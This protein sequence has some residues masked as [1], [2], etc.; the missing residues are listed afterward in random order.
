MIKRI[1]LVNLGLN[2]SID[3]N[4][5]SK[6]SQKEFI[7][8]NKK[9]EV[10]RSLYEFYVR[11]SA[12]VD[13]NDGYLM[14]YKDILDASGDPTGE[15]TTTK[16]YSDA[17]R[18]YVGAS[19]LPDIIGGFNTSVTYKDFDFNALF[20]F[21]YGSYVYD[22]SYERLMNTTDIAGQRHADIAERWRKPGD[23]TKVPLLLNSQNY[24]GATSSRF[25]FKNDYIRLKAISIGYSFKKIF[26]QRLN[27]SRFR[28][29][30][31]GDNIFTY[32][33]HKGI[34]PEQNLSGATN[35]RSYQ[36]KT[37]SLGV[38]VQF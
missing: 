10:G 12:G 5:I 38:N 15:R 33:T 37:I 23:I 30:L 8:D 31:Q 3:N 20:N 7:N 27:L 25:L 21:S 17:D 14:W 13:P 11:E 6:L 35:N 26:V 19:S 28:L 2:F 24:F 1:L 34:D 29:Y 4:E 18:Y 36:L 9:W 22:Y 16:V 32:Q